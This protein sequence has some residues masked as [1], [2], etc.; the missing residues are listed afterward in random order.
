MEVMSSYCD[1]SLTVQHLEVASVVIENTNW[2]L[3][4]SNSV[5]IL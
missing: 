1:C 5:S 2:L 4:L 3:D